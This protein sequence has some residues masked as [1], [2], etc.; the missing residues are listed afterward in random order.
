MARVRCDSCGVHLWSIM[1]LLCK[2]AFCR[3]EGFLSPSD[4]EQPVDQNQNASHPSCSLTVS[5]RVRQHLLR[6]ILIPASEAGFAT[7][8]SGCPFDPAADLYGSMQA[9]EASTLGRAHGRACLADYCELFGVCGDDAKCD[10]G[11]MARARRRCDQALATCFPLGAGDSVARTLHSRYSR[12]LCQMLDCEVRAHHTDHEHNKSLLA[13]S[14]LLAGFS[15]LGLLSFG[16]LFLF[17]DGGEDFLRLLTELGL[18]APAT[19][20]GI[21]GLREV[22]RVTAGFDRSKAS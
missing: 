21:R 15:V 10:G 19:G 22:L 16:C 17:L 14:P 11:A 9:T 12:Q 5:Q 18:L 7:W 1:L 2:L 4:K 3:G 13:V 20:A 6:E 8:P